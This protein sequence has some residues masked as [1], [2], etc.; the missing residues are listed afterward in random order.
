VPSIEECPIRAA[1]WGDKL[2][3]AIMRKYMKSSGEFGN[4]KVILTTKIA[5][6]FLL[7]CA[8][9]LL[10]SYKFILFKNYLISWH[11]S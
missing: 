4:M 7:P 9:W 1:A 6:F 5:M 2:M 3:Q 8:S 10:S 11:N